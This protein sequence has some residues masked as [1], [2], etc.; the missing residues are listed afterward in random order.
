MANSYQFM[1]LSGL[2]IDVTGG[3]ATP[4]TP[5]QV[6]TRNS[7]PS[8]NQLWT[9][10]SGPNPGY[11]FINSTL[12]PNL[13]IDVKGGTA[14]PGTPLQVW[15]RNSPPSPNQLWTFVPFVS[16]APVPQGF[17]QSLLHP[18]LVIDIRGGV[19]KRGTPLQIWTKNPPASSGNQQWFPLHV[20][21][22][23]APRIVGIVPTGGGFSMNG[24]GLQAGSP[25][26]GNYIFLPQGGGGDTGTFQTNA[27]LDGNF[28]I[29]GTIDLLNQGP[30]TLQIGI[31]FSEP[32]FP[33]EISADWNGSAFTNLTQ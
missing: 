23:F 9:F 18:N 11:Y 32:G 16:G 12:G 29:G 33:R 20:A 8:P 19:L 22:S 28:I 6:W 17:I 27:D 5:L 3:T 21:G 25:L 13:V 26:F 15:T 4:G 2:W 1:S 30:G 24:G 10:A 31:I 14:T 7:P